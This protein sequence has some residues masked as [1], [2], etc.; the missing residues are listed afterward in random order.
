[1]SCCREVLSYAAALGF[2]ALQIRI[3]TFKYPIADRISVSIS[4]TSKKKGRAEDRALDFEN[5]V[6]HTL[7]AITYYCEKHIE[8]HPQNI[9]NS[10]KSNTKTT[11]K[12]SPKLP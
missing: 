12:T 4:S 5:H 1:M 3:Q 2:T 8:N 6:V 7:Y 11:K 10:N 9:N